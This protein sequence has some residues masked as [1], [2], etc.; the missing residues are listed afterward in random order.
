MTLL[1][2]QINRTNQFDFIDVEDYTHVFHNN[3]S[4]KLEISGVNFDYGL[5][6]TA[7]LRINIF[8][9]QELLINARE[10]TLQN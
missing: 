1:F 2:G 5:H 8:L 4:E 7:S 3:S 9:M 6:Y 10:R